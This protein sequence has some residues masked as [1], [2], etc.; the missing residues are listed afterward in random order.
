[1]AGLYVGEWNELAVQPSPDGG[2]F[3][4]TRRTLSYL[5]LPEGEFI[6]QAAGEGEWRGRWSQTG[7]EVRL[8][9]QSGRFERLQIVDSEHLRRGQ[10]ALSKVPRHHDLRL[11]G[12]YEGSEGTVTFFGD[13]HFDAGDVRGSYTIEGNTIAMQDSEGLLEA[14]TLYASGNDETHILEL[15]IDGKRYRRRL[16]G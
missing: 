14:A 11:D 13:G 7:G 9:D 16:D 1:M 12:T 6:Y 4:R 15:M 8:Q 3:I 5:L 2:D 10:V